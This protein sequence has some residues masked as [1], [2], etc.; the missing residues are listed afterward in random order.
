MVKQENNDGKRVFI[1]EA[2]GFAY[3]TVPMAEKCEEYCISHR[4]CSLDI[5]K[6]ALKR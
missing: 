6:H 5:T 3:A 4:S 2:C 1:C